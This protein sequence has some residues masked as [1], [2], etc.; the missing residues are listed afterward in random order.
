MT[1]YVDIQSENH[2]IVPT[3][4]FKWRFHFFNAHKTSDTSNARPPLSWGGVDDLPC[5]IGW[6][7]AVV[8]NEKS[9]KFGD[10]LV[11][12]IHA[13]F[14]LR[15]LYITGL[16]LLDRAA[17]HLGW[18]YLVCH[19]RKALHLGRDKHMPWMGLLFSRHDI[20]WTPILYTR[21]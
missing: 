17:R 21:S 3:T 5:C 8:A 15:D 13:S 10:K 6:K 18:T 16:L 11:S 12:L 14:L 20:I 9:K 2:T 19:Y 1:W 4:F 7:L